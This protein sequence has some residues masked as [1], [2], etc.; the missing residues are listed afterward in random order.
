MTTTQRRVSPQTGF[1]LVEVMVVLIIFM[2]VTGAVF[3]LLNVAQIRYAAEKRFL[4]S[5]QGARIGVDLMVRDIHNA[6]YPRPYVYPGNFPKLPA[7]PTPLLIPDPVPWEVPTQAA[8]ALQERF[9]VGIVG[10]RNGVVD[11][12]CTVNGGATPCAVPN[13]FDLILETDIDPETADP[14]AGPD[15]EWVRY[16]LCWIQADGTCDPTKKGPGDTS[17][18]VRAVDVKDAVSNPAVV[19]LSNVPF[20][21]NIVQDPTV[22]VG[23]LL[24][25]GTR[26]QA[27]FNYLCRGGAV[28]CTVEEIE[29]IIIIVRVRSAD[30]DLQTRQAREITLRGLAQRLNPSR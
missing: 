7:G 27:V 25:D 23:N 30:P 22:P 11:L 10:V 5:F 3:G 26:N 21:E 20:V 6:G 14:V 16:Q 19:V 9:A 15:I 18:L 12:G 29:S 8:A 1:S 4:E 24:P 2:I 13:A 17:V 28:S